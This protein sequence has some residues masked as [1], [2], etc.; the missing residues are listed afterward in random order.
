MIR[1]AG[2]FAFN[3]IAG[4]AAHLILMIPGFILTAMLFGKSDE[5][6][7]DLI[8]AVVMPF[9]G[10]GAFIAHRELQKLQSIPRWDGTGQD[11]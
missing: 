6:V 10:A 11:F 9:F 3:L 1:N 8:V 2:K 5:G 7:I 4:T